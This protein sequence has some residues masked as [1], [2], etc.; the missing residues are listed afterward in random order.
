M[1][2]YVTAKVKEIE[3]WLSEEK[4]E[5]RQGEKTQLRKS[6][7]D[8]F[9]KKGEQKCLYTQDETPNYL[10]QWR[11][12]WVCTI[13]GAYGRLTRGGAKARVKKE[14]KTRVCSAKSLSVFAITD[15]PHAPSPG[16]GCEMLNTPPSPRFVADGALK[17]VAAYSP[18]TG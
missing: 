5:E 13:C 1:Q 7:S 3:V 4:G 15:S 17:V 9:S 16:R 10:H 6:G 11:K 8:L 14:K 18:D 12:K 2:Q